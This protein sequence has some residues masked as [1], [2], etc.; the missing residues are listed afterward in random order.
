MGAQD[1]TFS[2][3][4]SLGVNKVVVTPP[5][6]PPKQP[7]GTKGRE[8][9]TCIDVVRRDILTRINVVQHVKVCV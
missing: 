8:D 6:K 4:E 5:P 2:T 9:A 3:E 7:K 1:S